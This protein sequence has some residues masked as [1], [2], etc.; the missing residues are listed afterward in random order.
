[1]QAYTMES[2]SQS[3]AKKR[4]E[5]H[6]EARKLYKQVYKGRRETLGLRHKDTE[7]LR[8]RLR[9]Y[10]ETCDVMSDWSDSRS[11]GTTFWAVDPAA[12]N[13]N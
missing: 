6:N 9:L 5:K 12:N 8:N 3:Q 1:M 2:E 7:E 11:N 4:R 10:E 13:S